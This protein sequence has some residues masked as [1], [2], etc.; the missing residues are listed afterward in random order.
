MPIIEKVRAEN[1]QVEQIILARGEAGRKFP[2]L[3]EMMKVPELTHEDIEHLA[4]TRPDS[5]EVAHMGPTGGTTGLPKVVPRTHNDYLCRAEYAARAWELSG[6]DTLLVVSPVTHDLTFSIGLCS[7]IFTFGRTVMLD[8]TDPQ[9][10]CRT[11]EEE[12]IT[13]VAWTPTFAYRLI[14]F[15]GL[16]DYDL[17]SLRVMYCGGGASSGELVKRVTETLGCDFLNGYGGT[18][19]MSTLPRLDYDLE[20]RCR[21]VGRPTCPYDTYRV[22]DDQGRELPPKTVGELAVKGPCIFTGY[23]KMREENARAFYEKGFF[24]TG[25]SAM[26][27]DAGDIILSGRIKD[28]I[29]RGGENISPVE[30]EHLIL[31]HPDVEAVAALGMPDPEMGE[32]ACAYIQTRPGANMDLETIVSFLKKQGASVLQFPERVECITTMPITGAKGLVD[33][34]A[35]LEDIQKKLKME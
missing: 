15:E 31:Q 18:E 33:K 25:D 4:A 26:I 21:T 3:K 32:R 9:S 27:D 13:T 5:T 20:R 24:R 7:T 29:V 17:S 6:R 30:I 16:G 35:L 14:H 10:I 1:P 12:G 34:K 22:V 11:I 28:I 19:G 8:S 2:S 23:Y